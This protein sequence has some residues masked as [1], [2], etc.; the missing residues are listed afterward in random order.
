MLQKGDKAPVFSLN[1]TPDQKVSLSD[2]AGK[3]VVLL[4]YP[5]DWSPVCGDEL[6]V[7]NT[8]KDM[9]DKENAQ[10]LGI[11]VDGVWSHDAFSASRGIHF[12]LLADF[13]PKGEVA[14]AYGVYNEENGL[15]DRAI[16]IVD[17]EGNIAWSYLSPVGVNPG[18]DGALQ[19]LKD[20]DFHK[21]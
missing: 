10:L 7:F 15:S 14:K 6:S 4:F 19:V 1:S 21:D 2:F 8:V 16:F 9:F 20:L 12:P 11:S 13:N 18:A 3:R 17:E 5:A